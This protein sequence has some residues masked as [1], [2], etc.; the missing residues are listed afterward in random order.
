MANENKLNLEDLTIQTVFADGD[1]LD[2]N[3]ADDEKDNNPDLNQDPPAPEGGEGDDS[4]DGEGNEGGDDENEGDEPSIFQALS[5]RLGY[6]VEGE[7]KEDYDGLA[8]YTKKVAEKMIESQ[9]G[10]LFKA[11][12]DVEEYMTFRLNGGNPKE[13]FGNT[14][15]TTDFASLEITE[16]NVQMQELVITELLRSQGF[17]AD[18]IKETIEDYKDT[19]IL[20][21]QAKKAHPKVVAAESSR[22][23][24]VLRAQ[25]KA[26]EEVDRAA[27]QRWAEIKSTIDKG[28]LKGFT[29][30]E[31]DKKEFY[32]W[33]SVPVDQSGKSKRA[34][35]REKMDT[36]TML[37][38]EYLFYKNFELGK[39]AQNIQNTTK[40]N[41]LREKLQNSNQGASARLKGGKGTSSTLKL[42]PL[43]E[44]I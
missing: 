23:E 16:D 30:P 33:L 6:E 39:L 38:M 43:K 5:E 35:D 7:F 13:F 4:K 25:A 14:E 8:E 42:P 2:S 15:T 12:P 1:V 27:E 19:N 28:A 31:K 11:L 36:E 41:N 34:L 20:Y 29:V 3:P 40:A 9:L 18:E 32:E 17:T 26:K 10:D 22:K 24:E 21:K 44:I 37:A